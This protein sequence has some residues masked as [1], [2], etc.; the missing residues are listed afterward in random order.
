[1]PPLDESKDADRP[2]TMKERMEE[3]R[4]NPVCANCHRLMDPIGLALETFDGIG[5]SR[6]RD[7]GVKID[8]A[9]ELADGTSVNGVIEL[10]QALL[11]RPETMVR[12]FTENLL[13]YAL[14][15]ALAP[16]DMPAVRAIL[17]KTAAQHY[18]M[19]DILQGVVT[20]VPF[21]MRIKAAAA[22]E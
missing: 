15:R 22:D 7:Q 8:A 11:R 5:A 16:E 20:S 18:R 10:R 1:V 12:T 9:T 2:M 19:G 13:T 14:G 6:V 21:Q 3:H 17:R 4:R